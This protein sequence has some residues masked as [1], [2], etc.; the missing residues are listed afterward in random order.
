[1]VREQLTQ[2]RENDSAQIRLSL[3]EP[4]GVNLRGIELEWKTRAGICPGCGS[5]MC[6]VNGF[7]R[8]AE[9]GYKESCC[10]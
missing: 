7:H 6:L 10:Y 2:R 1:M 8:C 5:K 9:C 4:D 3:A